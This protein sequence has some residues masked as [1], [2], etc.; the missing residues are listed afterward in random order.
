[1]NKYPLPPDLAALPV[2]VAH[3]WCELGPGQAFPT[4][5]GACFDAES[6]LICGHRE[7]PWSDVLQIDPDTRECRVLYH[8]E[9]ASLIGFAAHRD[10]RVFCADIHGR[11]PVISPSGT[12]ERDLLEGMEGQF[13]PND[14][15]FDSS[16][17]IY[18]SNFIGTPAQPTGAIY[19]LDQSEDYCKLHLVADHLV[20]PNGISFS[21]DFDILW[22]AE[23][24]CN[25]V[26]RIALGPDGY[27]R[28]HFSAQLQTYRNSGF[29]HVDS[30]SV[31]MDGNIY[32]AVMEGGRAIVLSPDGIPTHSILLSDRADGS[33]MKTP[34]LAIHPGRPE[35]FM[36]ACGAGGAWVYKF[37]ALAQSAPL[38]ANM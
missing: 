15:C 2:I 38:Y 28:K 4:V 13:K 3:P 26:T 33:R 10:G 6:R 11:L 23:S 25:A 22:T 19:R 35:G 21:P 30:N 16:G 32:Q 27:K 24:L 17:N 8:D 29:P 12:L 9:N 1:M 18:F 14:L 5:E 20:T 34:N 31:D 7:A 37:E 36:L